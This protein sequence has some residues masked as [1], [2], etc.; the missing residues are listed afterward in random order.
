MNR[1]TKITAAHAPIVSGKDAG[2]ARSPVAAPATPF[3]DC[4][5][6][7]D[8]TTYW[9]ALDARDW[10]LGPCR[11]CDGSRVVEAKCETCGGALNAGWCEAC[12]DFGLVYVERIAPGRIAL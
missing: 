9:L 12:D 4:P 3:I 11:T 10:E 5:D 2:V 8:G 7:T 6:C 1:P